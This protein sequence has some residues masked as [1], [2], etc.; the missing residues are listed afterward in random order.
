MIVMSY[1]SQFNAC[2]A[3]F[4][5]FPGPGKT[6]GTSIT[7]VVPILTF[8]Y[9]ADGTATVSLNNKAYKGKVLIPEKVSYN[10]Q[11][12]TVT[13]VAQYFASNAKLTEFVIPKTIKNWPSVAFIFT[14]NCKRV[15]YNAVNAT[16]YGGGYSKMFDE[17]V[18]EIIVGK[19]VEVLPTGFAW[20]TQITQID[21]PESLKVIG[22]YAFYDCKKLTSIT[23]PSNVT[24]IGSVAFSGCTALKTIIINGPEGSI[25]GY[26]WGA[27]D[28]TTVIWNG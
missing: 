21:L 4:V 3:I 12:Y 7:E 26:P 24:S 16:L 25:T 17:C 2:M 11:I 22:Q 23:I 14:D 1:A 8:T 15:T 6:G 13:T 20:D 5:A 10:G 28:T 27:P 9:N 18:E 19:S